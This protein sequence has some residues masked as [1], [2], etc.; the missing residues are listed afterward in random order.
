MYAEETSGRMVAESLMP[1]SWEAEATPF[2]GNGRITPEQ[3]SWRGHGQHFLMTP[4]YK[5]ES[6]S[7]SQPQPW[8]RTTGCS[9]VQGLDPGPIRL[10]TSREAVI[11]S[12]GS[13]GPGESPNDLDRTGSD[14]ALLRPPGH[15]AGSPDA[16]CS[17]P[18]L[19]PPHALG[20]T[21]TTQPGM[22]SC[23]E[24]RQQC[25]CQEHRGACMRPLSG[26]PNDPDHE[27]AYP[28]TLGEETH[29]E[30]Q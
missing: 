20:T 29:Q 15:R 2:T 27:Q 24:K 17:R 23:T 25:E 4:R 21:L 10:H 26:L 30:R 9:S 8:D 12:H 16:N 14:S 5:P 6:G 3:V 28:H 19:P 18:C 11:T 7:T 1:R 13:V 22:R